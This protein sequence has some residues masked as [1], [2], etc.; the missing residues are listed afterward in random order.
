MSQIP[1][2]ALGCRHGYRTIV[3]AILRCA[4]TQIHYGA[5]A[6]LNSFAE[7]VGIEGRKRYEA[8]VKRALVPAGHKAPHPVWPKRLKL[9]AGE[10]RDW[11][12][13]EIVDDAK[14]VA[15][16]ARA[17]GRSR[18]YLRGYI[19]AIDAALRR[20]DWRAQEL[21]DSPTRR[22]MSEFVQTLRHQLASLHAGERLIWIRWP[23][24]VPHVPRRYSGAQR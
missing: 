24:A 4:D 8:L 2:E 15:D 14:A 10:I 11:S 21:G 18:D 9:V 17:S 7:V 3:T 19:N 23:K 13:A 5:Q 16:I 1:Q 22:A 12:D 20:V 6:S